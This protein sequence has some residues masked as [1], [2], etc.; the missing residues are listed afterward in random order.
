MS[1]SATNELKKILRVAAMNPNE[2]HYADREAERIVKQNWNHQT[3]SYS[4][5]R[6]M[7]ARSLQPMPMPPQPSQRMRDLQDGVNQNANVA[8]D[9]N[10]IPLSVLISGNKADFLTLPE[11]TRKIIANN[12][13]FGSYLTEQQKNRIKQANQQGKPPSPVQLYII[14]LKNLGFGDGNDPKILQNVAIDNSGRFVAPPE[15]VAKMQEKMNAKSPAAAVTNATAQNEPIAKAQKQVQELKKTEVDTYK[16]NSFT[17]YLTKPG[18]IGGGP[19]GIGGKSVN[20]NLDPVD[21]AK[22]VVKLYSDADLMQAIAKRYGIDPE[23]VTALRAEYRAAGGW[24]M[25]GM[26]G[27]MAGGVQGLAL[28]ANQG[29][30]NKL[31][32]HKE[33]QFLDFFDKLRKLKTEVNKPKP[34]PQILVKLIKDSLYYDDIT[35]FDKFRKIALGLAEENVKIEI[36]K[37]TEPPKPEET[38]KPEPKPEETKKPEEA[39]TPEKKTDEKKTDEKKPDEEEILMDGKDISLFKKDGTAAKAFNN[40]VSTKFVGIVEKNGKQFLHMCCKKNKDNKSDA[41]VPDYYV[42][43]TPE[44]RAKFGVPSDVSPSPPAKNAPAKDDPAKDDPAKLPEK[45][46]PEAPEGIRTF[47]DADDAAK[48]ILKDAYMKK[49]T[50][51]MA[52]KLCEL[53]EGECPDLMNLNAPQ[54]IE[55][56]NKVLKKIEEKGLLIKDGKFSIPGSSGG[57]AVEAAPNKPAAEAVVA[58]PGDLGELAKNINKLSKVTNSG[59]QSAFGV[60]SLS[61]E[62]M[63]QFCSKF[64]C[65]QHQLEAD[66]PGTNPVNKDKL[67]A[68]FAK[69]VDK[70]VKVEGN[71]LVI[72]QRAEYYR[73]EDL[74]YRLFQ[75][76]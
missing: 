31:E 62:F 51:K 68:L 4:T 59:F 58:K 50:G 10:R 64:D 8:R 47:Q 65:A 24:N 39:E 55:E 16:M 46:V 9:L 72:N 36:K 41:G 53:L 15:V 73:S 13:L 75:F 52:V 21:A 40:K 69:I 74:I 33:E 49:Y 28:K 35:T 63:Q 44:N 17:D 45:A 5:S 43:D 32:G 29:L 48:F 70:K 1:T 14:S 18:T 30:Q 2:I 67:L 56:L 38:K 34:D 61:K 27:K 22:A 19:G 42:L 11:E 23:E 7:S 66:K 54:K 37:A 6:P 60:K 3:S 12:P 57:A 76:A 25:G 20:L 71:K 26:M